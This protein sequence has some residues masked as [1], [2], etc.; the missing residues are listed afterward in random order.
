VLA[1]S[2]SSTTQAQAAPPR[3]LESVDLIRLLTVVGVVSVHTVSLTNLAGSVPAG[4]A[5][6]VLHVNREIFFLLTALVLTYSW[7]SRPLRLGRFFVRRYWLVIT[8]YLAW[9]VIYFAADRG[10][11]LPAMQAL[12]QLAYALLTG[13]ARYHL[14]FLLVTMQIYLVFPLL[15]WF[16]RATRGRHGLVL[17]LSLALQLAFTAVVKAGA[18]P[19]GILGAWTAHPDVLLPSYQLYVVA[20]AVAADHLHRLVDLVRRHGQLVGLVSLSVLLFA[21]GIYLRDV[22]ANRVPPGDASVVF[23]PVVVLES[24]AAFGGLFAL[25]VHWAGRRRALLVDPLIRQGAIR[26]FGIFLVHPLVLQA[27]L[28]LGKHSGLL[29]VLDQAPAGVT[30]AVSLLIVAPLVLAASWV[31]VGLAQRSPLSLAMT[32][33]PRPSSH[34]PAHRKPSVPAAPATTPDP[35]TPP[36]LR[37]QSGAVANQSG[38]LSRRTAIP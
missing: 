30:L 25:G 11:Q 35:L 14:Y 31:L 7:G 29:A 9:T 8:P 2:P 37:A 17:A 26:S 19:P 18:Q 13:S 15:L 28:A 36:P 1:V 23:Q 10:F 4:A 22:L 34:A 16:V 6:V 3:H 24:L 33:R 12:R 21:V 20:G 38:D 32:G 27:V 5:A